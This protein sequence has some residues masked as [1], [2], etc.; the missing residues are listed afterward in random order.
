MG[1][2]LKDEEV[3]TWKKGDKGEGRICK[4]TCKVPE[5]GGSSVPQAQRAIDNVV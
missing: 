2:D 4:S 3:L 1:S 5:E